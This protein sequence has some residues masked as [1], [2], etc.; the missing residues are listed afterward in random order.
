MLSRLHVKE[1]WACVCVL[2]RS[3]RRGPSLSGQVAASRRRQARKMGVRP[4]G[5]KGRAE[6]RP[7]QARKREAPAGG[8]KRN[9]LRAPWGG[10]SGRGAPA[11]N[12]SGR[13]SQRSNVGCPLDGSPGVG[14]HTH[15]AAVRLHFMQMTPLRLARCLH[16][17]QTP[18]GHPLPDDC[19]FCAVKKGRLHS[20][21]AYCQRGPCLAR[22]AAHW[23][24]VRHAG[25]AP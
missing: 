14:S 5:E 25:G 10:G 23:P 11:P 4:V 3:F 2:Q 22:P 8:R 15:I 13:P 6:Q 12:C 7:A 20:G 24:A 9:Q 19:S 16:P 17:T 18:R 21:H 1:R